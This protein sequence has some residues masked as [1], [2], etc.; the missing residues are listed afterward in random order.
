MVLA[1]QSLPSLCHLIDDDVG[2]FGT[3]LL[4]TRCAERIRI[5][6]L[7]HRPPEWSLENLNKNEARP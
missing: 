2:A 7:M 6:R 4:V 1:N 3:P 5:I